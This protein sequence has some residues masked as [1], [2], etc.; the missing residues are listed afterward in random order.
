[1]SFSVRWQGSEPRSVCGAAKGRR[2]YACAPHPRECPATP[3]GHAQAKG[4]RC[5]T[6]SATV[7]GPQRPSRRQHR[8]ATQWSAIF[9]TRR[10]RAIR[11]GASVNS[12]SSWG[13]GTSMCRRWATATTWLFRYVISVNIH[14]HYTPMLHESASHSRSYEHALSIVGL[15]SAGDSVA[16]RLAGRQ[17]P[18]PEG[19]HRPPLLAFHL[20]QRRLRLGQP[21]GHVHSAI[22]GDG[23]GQLSASLLSLACRDCM[24]RSF[25]PPLSRPVITATSTPIPRGILLPR[26]R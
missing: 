9:A 13:P 21:E 4:I 1:M 2:T 10:L 23:S 5:C 14:A 24:V 22:Q 8:R 11:N 12:R 15:C 19:H 6:P 7:A 18:L 26:R 3:H 17:A 25:S 16:R 20:R